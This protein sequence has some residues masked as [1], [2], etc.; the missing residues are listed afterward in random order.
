MLDRM[1]LSESEGASLLLLL[2]DLCIDGEGDESL[3]MFP[4]VL[5]TCRRARRILAGE[6]EE[7]EGSDT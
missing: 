7:R 1:S 5:K 6:R 2:D 4:F 3:T